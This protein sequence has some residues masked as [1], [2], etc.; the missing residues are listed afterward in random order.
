MPPSLIAL[1]MM[2]FAL[3]ASDGSAAPAVASAPPPP[4]PAAA[5][6]ATPA[7]S[8]APAAPPVAPLPVLKGVDVYGTDRFDGAWVKTRFGDVLQRFFGT[9]D[10]AE[11]KALAKEMVEVILAEHKAIGWIELSPIIYYDRGGVMKAYVTVDVVERRDMKKRLTFGLQPKGDLED[12]AGLL[13][14]WK[15]YQDTYFRMMHKKEIGPERAACPAFHCLGGYEHEALRPY[16]E[17]F[18]ND[19]PPNE[20]KLIR[21]L[22]AD[23]DPEDRGAAAFLLAH[24]KDGEK[25]VSLMLPVLN[26][27]DALVRNNAMRVVAHVAM[28]HHDVPIPLTPF[29]KALDG[30][31]TTDRNKAAAVTW[32]LIDRPEGTKLYAQVIEEAGP[33]LLKLLK[34]EQPNNHDFAYLILKKVSGKDFPERDYAAWEKWLAAAA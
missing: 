25:L 2:A 13:A 3:P 30:P 23:K 6:S 22:E 18:V 4:P 5:P 29:L 32:G 12:P 19:V 8:A 15:D 7:A 26:D 33:T 21:I 27:P 1:V 24:I 31:T 14:A 9:E 16:G 10:E 34:L 11:R 20:D 28:F 17:R